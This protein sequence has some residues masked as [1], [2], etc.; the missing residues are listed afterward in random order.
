M[1]YSIYRSHLGPG[2]NSLVSGYSGVSEMAH[3]LSRGQFRYVDK[4]WNGR[5]RVGGPVG[6]NLWGYRA[7]VP[8]VLGGF[9]R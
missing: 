2:L 1:Y 5:L 6:R 8:R 7:S 4:V 9:K 3:V